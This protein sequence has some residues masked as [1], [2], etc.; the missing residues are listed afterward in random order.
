[1]NWDK[2]N[3][4]IGLGIMLAITALNLGLAVNFI[5]AAGNALAAAFNGQNIYLLAGIELV[6]VL[7]AYVSGKNGSTSLAS[8]RRAGDN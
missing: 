6:L 1:M 7:F 4:S 5:G 3:S 2:K 8:G